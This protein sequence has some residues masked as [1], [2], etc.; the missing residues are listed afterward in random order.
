MLAS[1]HVALGDAATTERGA[2]EQRVRSA[3][4]PRLPRRRNPVARNAVPAAATS[5]NTTASTARWTCGSRICA[6]SWATL[7]HRR[8]SRR[9]GDTATCSRPKTGSDGA[10]FPAAV[11]CYRRDVGD[12]ELGTGS[13]VA[14]VCGVRTR[15]PT[16]VV[17]SRGRSRSSN[18]SC[19]PFLQQRGPRSSRSWRRAPGWIWRSWSAR[20]SPASS[21]CGL[22]ARRAGAL[23]DADD[24]V[25][26][27]QR[28]ADSDA[29]WHSDSQTDLAPHAARM[30]AGHRVLRRD[31]ARHHA[32]AVATHARPARAGALDDD[33][34]IATGASTRRSAALAVSSLANA[35]R[36]MAAES[37]VS[38]ARTRT[39]PTRCR[40]RSRRRSR[41]CASRSSWRAPLK[42]GAPLS[43]SII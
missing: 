18:N 31:R 36:R 2:V 4:L 30:G 11:L 34:A 14:H 35:F 10:P 3:V 9:C 19:N 25:W 32:L 24:R 29:C 38:S 15:R 20:S 5:V 42:I 33:S 8:R 39:C 17:T 12:R 1:I 6:R 16:A 13:V 37:M 26:A 28:L 21:T 40:T 23:D 43:T 27:L 7:A 22:D 41:A